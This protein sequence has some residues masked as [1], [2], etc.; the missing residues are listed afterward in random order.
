MVAEWVLLQNLAVDAGL[1][2]AAGALARVRTRGWRVWVGAAVGAGY[3]LAA[4]YV[5]ALGVLA[6]LLGV[7]LCAVVV[8]GQ[9]G[10]RKFAAFVLWFYAA[11]GALA[12]V[13]VSLAM[14]LRP[15]SAAVQALPAWGLCVACLVAGGWMR[16]AFARR[17]LAPQDVFTGELCIRV[18]LAV[19]RVPALVDTGSSLREPVTGNP[20]AVVCRAPLME[21]FGALP[22]ATTPVPYGALSGHGTLFAFA[23]DAMVLTLGNAV[24]P[25][26]GLVAPGAAVDYG[27]GVQALIPLGMLELQGGKYAANGSKMGVSPEALVGAAAGGPRLG[28]LHRR[29]RHAARP[30]AARRRARGH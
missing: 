30:T 27:E 6:W 4:A 22:A 15:A 12:G 13:A 25:C 26:H 9:V 17:S 11:S 29:Q 5:P 28:A 2:L 16:A 3:A 7:G 20:V 8:A 23:P 18:G 1:L 14:L 21:A 24:I 19:C 10:W